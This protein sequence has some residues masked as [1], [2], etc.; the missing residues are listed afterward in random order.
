MQFVYRGSLASKAFVLAFCVVGALGAGAALMGADGA[1][2]APG[3]APATMAAGRTPKDIFADIRSLQTEMLKGGPVPSFA[4]LAVAE[5]RTKYAER[6][7]DP[8]V[9]LAGLEDELSASNPGPMTQT[10]PGGVTVM[11]QGQRISYLAMACAM[12]SEEAGKQ[13]ATLA[14]SGDKELAA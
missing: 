10:P 14:A 9:K 11:M 4:A 3:T 1:A 8:Y 2:T 5:N 12:G 7:R 13:L 6:L